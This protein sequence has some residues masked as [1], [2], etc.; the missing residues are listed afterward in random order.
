MKA[1]VFLDSNIFLY[2]ASGIESDAAKKAVAL[3]L[4]VE[5]DFGVSVQVLGEF[6]DNVRRKAK[7]AISAETAAEIL[8]LM[9]R[10]PL[11]EITNRLFDQAILLSLRFQIRYYDAAILAAAKQ[12]GAVTL[13]SEDLNNGQDYDGVKVVNPFHNLR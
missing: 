4:I 6:Y 8:D 9:R 12:L 10:R 13:F 1:D 11:V 3:R 7:L 2:A 5:T